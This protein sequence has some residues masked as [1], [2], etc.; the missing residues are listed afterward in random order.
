MVKENYPVFLTCRRHFVD[1]RHAGDADAGGKHFI[2]NLNHL[3]FFI[4]PDHFFGGFPCC[5]EL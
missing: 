2:G 5:T 1:I 3:G 4:F